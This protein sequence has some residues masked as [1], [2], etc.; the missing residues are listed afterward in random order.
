[1]TPSPMW[2]G[3]RRCAVPSPPCRFAIARSSC[4]SF[5][6]ELSNAELARAL[7]ISESNAGTRLHRALT[8]LRELCSQVDREEVA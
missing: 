6:A 7:G 1:M 8:R 5:T 2:S 4:S 3:A